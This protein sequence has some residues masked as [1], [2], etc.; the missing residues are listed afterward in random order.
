V[1]IGFGGLSSLFQAALE[2]KTT[3]KSSIEM[4]VAIA[5]R[6]VLTV[7]ALAVVLLAR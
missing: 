7:A 6:L 5:K 4:V 2:M 3:L 1:G